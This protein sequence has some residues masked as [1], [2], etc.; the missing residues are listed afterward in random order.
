MKS[1]NNTSQE[2]IINAAVRLVEQLFKGGHI[3]KQMCDNAKKAAIAKLKDTKI[4]L[5][6]KAR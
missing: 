5:T 6:I 3:S 4:R 1:K 2:F